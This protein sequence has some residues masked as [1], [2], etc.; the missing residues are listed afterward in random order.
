M[1]IQIFDSLC[2]KTLMG[3]LSRWTKYSKPVVLDD[4]FDNFMH[5]AEYQAFGDLWRVLAGMRDLNDKHKRKANQTGYKRRHI[6]FQ[7]LSLIWLSNPRL[8]S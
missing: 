4:N 6:F 5:A 3:A 8:L 7:I 2:K 1:F